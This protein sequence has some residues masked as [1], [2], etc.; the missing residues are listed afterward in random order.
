VAA[1]L[2]RPCV[3]LAAL[4][5]ASGAAAEPARAVAAA[6]AAAARVVAA[7]AEAERQVIEVRDAEERAAARRVEAAAAQAALR[8]H[9]ADEAGAEEGAA[10]HDALAETMQREED[11][12]RE[13]QA[14]DLRKHAREVALRSGE[15]DRERREAAGAAA[16]R[17]QALAEKLGTA[18]PQAPAWLLAQ[19]ALRARGID[20]AARGGAAAATDADDRDDGGRAAVDGAA[21]PAAGRAALDPREQARQ[22]DR[23]QRMFG[24]N[25]RMLKQRAVACWGEATA[26]MREHWERLRTRQLGEAVAQWRRNARVQRRLNRFFPR[27]VEAVG[28]RALAAA[29]RV[30]VENEEEEEQTEMEFDPNEPSSIEEVLLKLQAAVVETHQKHSHLLEMTRNEERLDALLAEL[31]PGGADALRQGGVFS[32]TQLARMTAGGA[33][34]AFDDSELRTMVADARDRETIREFLAAPAPAAAEEGGAAAE[35]GAA[36]LAAGAAGAFDAKRAAMLKEM[37]QLRE[38]LDM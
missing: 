26:V 28:R 22:E 24:R 2:D 3:E 15:A 5:V 19:Q 17:F 4:A 9:E 14:E 31:S 27:H 38:Q 36:A 35:E 6:H 8:S 16:A 7:A 13:A 10:G 32:V 33:P 20:F 25:E 30:W 37:A 34:G 1:F 29:F 21:A 23:L 18:T 12:R 11:A